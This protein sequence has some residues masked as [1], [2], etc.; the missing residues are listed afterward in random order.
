VTSLREQLLRW[1]YNVSDDDTCSSLLTAIGDEN[2]VI[3]GAGLDPKGL[4]NNGGPGP[5][6]ADLSDRA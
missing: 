3:P 2:N 6:S 4:Q 5:A 1:G